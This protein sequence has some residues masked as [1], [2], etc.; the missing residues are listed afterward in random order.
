MTISALSPFLEPDN[1]N[2]SAMIGDAAVH[3][4]A[5]RGLRDLSSRAIARHLGISGPA[6]T[7]QACRTEQ[8]RL[9]VVALGRRWVRWSDSSYGVDVPARL[10]ETEDELHGVRV[11]T[12][13]AE[14]A[15]GEAAGG[16][17]EPSRLFTAFCRDE[18]DQTA[19]NLGRLLERQPDELEVAA[20]VALVSGLRHELA[21]GRPSVTFPQAQELLL[22]HVGRLGPTQPVRS[23]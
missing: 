10:P 17:P 6:L 7:L 5:T 4:L 13:L 14:L 18:R 19:W 16:N 12:A 9:L 11:W 8:L 21:A 3:L 1:P 22:E 20:T 23:A 15:R 2:L